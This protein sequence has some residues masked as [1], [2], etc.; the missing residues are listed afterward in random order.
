MRTRRITTANVLALACLAIGALQAPADNALP[1]ASFEQAAGNRPELWT[2]ATWG[3]SGRF[4]YADIGHTGGHSVLIEADKGGDLSW[5]ISVPVE[6]YSTYR[7]S[8]WIKTENVTPSNGRGALFNIH[9]MQQ[10]RT[11]ALTGT[12]DWTQLSIEFDAEDADAVQVNALFGGWGLATGKAWFDDVALERLATRPLNPT[13]A[14]D[15]SQTSAPMNPYIYGQFIE[16]L[17]RCIYGGIWAEMLEDRK[18]W[19]AV[20]AKESPWKAIGA[21]G[22]VTMSKEDAYVG[23]HSPVIRLTNGAEA[24]IVQGALGLVPGKTYVGRVVL[25]GLEMNGKLA[26]RLV[27]GPGDRD[28]AVIDLEP[29]NGKDTTFP[30]SF[31]VPA[32]LPKTI[33]DGRLE[34]VGRGTGALRIGTASLMPADNVHGMRADTLALLKE[35][36]SPI[37]RWPGG[38]FVSGYNWRD[39]IG[40][41]DKRPPRKNPAWQGVEHND[42]GIDEYMLFCRLIDTEPYVV[43]NSG[44][45]GVEMAIEELEYCNGTTATVMGRRRARNGHPE[46][47]KVRIWGIGNE[48]Y[49]NWQL[50]HMP[51]AE[52]VKKHNAFAEAMRKADPSIRL[53]AVGAVGPWSETMLRESAGHMD[54]LSEHF[55]VQEQPGLLAHVRLAPNQVRR[56]AQAHRRYRRTIE[57]LHEKTVPVALDEWNYWYGPHVY[58]ELGTQYFLKDA[59]G[60]AA[61]L[62]EFAR[63]TDVYEMANY[64]Q[65]VNVIGAIKTNKTAAALDTTGLALMMYRRYFGAIPVRADGNPFPLDVAAAWSADRKALTIAVVNATRETIVLPFE[66]QGAS[67]TGQGRLWRL[68]GPDPKSHNVPGEAPQVVVVEEGVRGFANRLA[69]APLS[70]TIYALEAKSE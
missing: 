39:G 56:I 51:L 24:G 65:T 11:R 66:L 54:M 17:G 10:V 7:L 32:D 63:N 1:N 57:P 55:Y 34:I 42:F 22:A 61:A 20:G 45:G 13:L 43:V 16:H 52:Y 18:F 19:Y 38:N 41:P 60:V 44:L 53:I 5:T 6:P 26:A 69:A 37:Y 68:T 49:G 30:L 62:Q 15:A 2:T 31:T 36:D 35:L 8:G 23:A 33:P 59:L 70:A 50:G 29:V 47:Y 64:A 25:K 46:P 12:N 4:A 9:N 40:D 21:E 58:G 28:R 14:I 27:F 67:L 48:M 3:G